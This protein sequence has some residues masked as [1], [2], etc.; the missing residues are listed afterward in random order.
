M[1]Y[2]LENG[3]RVALYFAGREFDFSKGNTLNFLHM[4][5]STRL[6]VPMIH[7]SLTDVSGWFSANPVLGDA[8]IIRV[9]ITKHEGTTSNN[10]VTEFAMN[11]SGGKPSA[12]G[13]VYQIDGYYDCPLYWAGSTSTPIKGTSYEVLS[14][15]CDATELTLEASGTN[16]SQIWY[17]R[18]E[19]FY[20][21]AK[22]VASHGYISDDSCLSMAVSMDGYLYYTDIATM[23]EEAYGF[24]L[25]DFTNPDVY[26]VVGYK[27][28]VASGTF[29]QLGGY[30]FDFVEQSLTRDTNRVFTSVRFNSNETG[31]LMVNNTV[32][33]A[34]SQSR[35]SFAPVDM[36][37]THEEY[38]RAYY[39]NARVSNLFTSGLE[40]LTE[41]MTDVPV[42]STVNF[43]TPT[44]DNQ[45]LAGVSAYAGKYRVTSKTIYIRGGRYVE[46]FEMVRRTLNTSVPDAT[47]GD[48]ATSTQ[49][50]VP[51]EFKTES[52]SLFP[53]LDGTT[54]VEGVS[55]SLSTS[56]T[57][58]LDSATSK[59]SNLAANAGSVISGPM[60][61]LTSL[62]NSVTSTMSSI[63]SA[64]LAAI[65]Q[66]KLDNA[67]ASASYTTAYNAYV[68]GGSVGTPPTAPTLIDLTALA[69]SYGASMTQALAAATPAISIQ[70]GRSVSIGNVQS[71]LTSKLTD[72]TTQ[73]TSACENVTGQIEKLMDSLADVTVPSVHGSLGSV[74]SS[75]QAQATTITS[76]V[77]SAQASVSS[78][79]T[80]AQGA[81]T[82]VTGTKNSF[83]ADLLHEATTP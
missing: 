12:A 22:R 6:G 43:T 51:I 81:L 58:S 46:K 7:L 48:T 77:S 79:I 34:L 29:N 38:Q 67:A 44:E 57:D 1:A 31:A 56:L 30:S 16:D 72:I 18:N 55:G 75:T 24:G 65:Q 2:E 40:I 76:A 53:S 26:T 9:D 17:P 10:T 35:V 82:T 66:A 19:P 62:T 39:Q 21:F 80:Q 49:L 28:F 8:V 61:Q 59:V 23:D 68:A 83:I 71:A 41:S 47:Q 73:L 54:L 15:I 33:D 78:A 36:G 70:Q 64:G 27:P 52:L 60:S 42:L 13:T 45:A 32:R 63:K 14:K 50:N 69:N 20:R 4:S 74:I 11:Y 37:N 5:E 25:Y 3:V